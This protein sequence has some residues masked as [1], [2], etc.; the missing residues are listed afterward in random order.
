MIELYWV[1]FVLAST[2]MSKL[3]DASETHSVD[4]LVTSPILF[5]LGVVGAYFVIQTYRP[6]EVGWWLIV[7]LVLA[8]CIGLIGLSVGLG[9]FATH[10]GPGALGIFALHMMWWA[11]GAALTAA[12]AVSLI[13]RLLRR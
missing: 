5:L 1:A 6:P 3:N 7:R 4:V 8:N 9:E 10:F 2:L 13:L 12:H 11:L